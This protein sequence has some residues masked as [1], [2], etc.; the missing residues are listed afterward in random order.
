MYLLLNMGRIGKTFALLLVPLFLLSLVTLQP[1][2]VKAQT[3]TLVVPD[4]YPTIQSAVGNASAGDTVLVKKGTYFSYGFNIDK[5]LRL[6]GQDSNSTII[7][8]YRSSRSQSPMLFITSSDVE[9]SGFS[10]SNCYTGIECNG[11]SLHGITIDCCGF[12]NNSF[13]VAVS[14]EATIVVKNCLFENNMEAI[15]LSDLFQ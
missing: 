3:K 11:K 14:S 8:G 6:I 4:Q 13:G 10:F 9:I 2:T 15:L 1:L 12:F 7:T 5:S